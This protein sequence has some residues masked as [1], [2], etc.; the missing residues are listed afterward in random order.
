[1]ST[2]ITINGAEFEKVTAPSAIREYKERYNR[3]EATDIFELYG[4]P[5]LSKIQAANKWEKWNSS[6]DADFCLYYNGGKMAGYFTIYGQKNLP[7]GQKMY[8]IIS[9]KTSNKYFIV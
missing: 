6:K 7:N 8:I 9:G 1:M 3:A 4:R 5:S 2:T